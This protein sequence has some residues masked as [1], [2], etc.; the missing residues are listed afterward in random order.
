MRG[1]LGT[2]AIANV[3][4]EPRYCNDWNVAMS[5]GINKSVENGDAF[6]RES[7]QDAPC[8]GTVSAEIRAACSIAHASGSL[9]KLQQ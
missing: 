6:R 9:M 4:P 8:P 3:M 2:L 1:V 5:A 7:V